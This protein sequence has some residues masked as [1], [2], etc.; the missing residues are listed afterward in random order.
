MSGRCFIAIATGQNVANVA[1][2]LAVARPAD[3]IVFIETAEAA[4]RDWT[5]PALDVLRKRGLGRLWRLTLRSNEP[6]EVYE[7]ARQFSWPAGKRVIIG[8][9]GTKPQSMALYEALRESEP[10]LLY[11]L[12]RPCVLQ[13]YENGPGA[14]ART[15][16]YTESPLRLDDVVLL[17][18]MRLSD[19]SPPLYWKQHLTPEGG[20]LAGLAEGYGF[21]PGP[22]FA[23]HDAHARYQAEQTRAGPPPRLPR[24]A[25]LQYL[26]AADDW[27]RYLSACA[28]VLKRPTAAVAVHNAQQVKDLF[29]A[30]VRLLERA[31]TPPH[32]EVPPAPLGPAFERALAARLCAVLAEGGDQ[33]GVIQGVWRN[34]KVDSPQAPG[35]IQLEA[36]LLIL[37]KNGLLIAI[38]AKSHTADNKDLDARLLSLQRAGSQLARVVVCSPLYTQAADR[39]WFRT[40][41]EFARRLRQHGFAH[42][43][44]T[45]PG[46]PGAYTLTPE[47]RTGA[48]PETFSVVPFETACRELL[49]GYAPPVG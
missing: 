15:E 23:L 4:R 35:I 25:E 3:A 17:R 44:Y 1:P 20:K 6:A 33:T 31:L 5:G 14:P 12:D 38:E 49:Q 47:G 45:L 48:A 16:P 8:N 27:Q 26:V 22:T 30:A 2:L 11:S 29:N 34:V 19:A 28:N 13:W 21:E 43:P 9:G 24:W 7:A 18:N 37:L 32:E 36:D 40:H 10:L 39:Q 41:H 42:L 46:Q